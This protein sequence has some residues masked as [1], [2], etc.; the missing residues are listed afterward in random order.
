MLPIF[1]G[2]RCDTAYTGR[3]SGAR[4]D[5]HLLVAAVDD[6]SRTA[7]QSFRLLYTSVSIP[8]LVSVATLRI[9]S[10]SKRHV[11]GASGATR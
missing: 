11:I 5:D 10:L 8:W 6:G 2:L 4:M 3:P 1:E 9:G 7:R